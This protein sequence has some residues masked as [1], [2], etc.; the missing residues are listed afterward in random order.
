MQTTMNI[1]IQ[2][3]K[4]FWLRRVYFTNFIGETH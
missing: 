3:A 4:V 1:F 2:T